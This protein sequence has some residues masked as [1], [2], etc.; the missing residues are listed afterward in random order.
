MCMC[1]FCVRR[2]PKKGMSDSLELDFQVVAVL[3]HLMWVMSTKLRYP[4]GEA[5]RVGSPL[6]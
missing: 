2:C 4:A 3:N 6:A 1:V 5:V